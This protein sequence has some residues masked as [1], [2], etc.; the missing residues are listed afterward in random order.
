MSK[1]TNE[2]YLQRIE[3]VQKSLAMGVSNSNIKRFIEE[4]WGVSV[5]TARRYLKAAKKLQDDLGNLSNL[6]LK[7][8]CL[9]RLEYLYSVAVASQKPELAAQ[10][11]EKMV[12]LLTTNGGNNHEQSFKEV[13]LSPELER[14]IQRLAKQKGEH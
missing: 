14:A 11:V 6:I 13:S 1:T 7:A 10:I 9:S 3:M 2:E 5:R 12:K 4:K 8:Q